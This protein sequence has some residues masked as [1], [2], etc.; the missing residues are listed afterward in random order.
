MFIIGLAARPDTAITKY[1]HG[2][3]IFSCEE[4]NVDSY[5]VTTRSICVNRSS[6]WFHI[7]ENQR[8]ETLQLSMKTPEAPWR[9][10]CVSSLVKILVFTLTIQRKL[11]CNSLQGDFNTLY[12]TFYHTQKWKLFLPSC[13][14]WCHLPFISSAFSTRAN[15]LTNLLTTLRTWSQYSFILHIFH[16]IVTGQM[17]GRVRECRS[18]AVDGTLWNF[19]NLREGPNKS[20]RFGYQGYLNLKD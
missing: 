9:M 5:A 19:T 4:V 8:K 20:G 14:K 15:L 1:F 18:G 13:S 2:A 16:F 3:K 10:L 12:I 11:K 6:S 17:E 7:E